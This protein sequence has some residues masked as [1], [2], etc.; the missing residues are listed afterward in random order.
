MRLRVNILPCIIQLVSEPELRSTN[1]ISCIFTAHIGGACWFLDYSIFQDYLFFPQLYWCIIGNIVKDYFLISVFYWFQE[2]DIFLKGG[3]CHV[4]LE[5]SSPAFI[6][7]PG[8]FLVPW[9]C[10]VMLTSS[11]VNTAL[12][13]LHRLVTWASKNR[14][15]DCTTGLP[16]WDFLGNLAN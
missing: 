14:Y 2:K 5:G 8:A 11:M 10:S 16:N 12:C 13:Q 3:P 7:A 6:T 9:T 15:H 4:P 1:C